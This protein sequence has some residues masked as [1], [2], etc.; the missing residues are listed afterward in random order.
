MTIELRYFTGT[1]NS[2]KILNTIKYFFCEA[3]HSV[4]ISIIKPGE[5]IP[6]CDLIGFCFPVYAFG[7][8]RIA[9]SY[10]KLI[11]AFKYGQKTFVI[12]TA[13][14]LDESGFAVREC[15]NLLKRKNCDVIYSHVVQ[16]P[17]N[18]ITAMNPPNKEEALEIINNGI[19][20]IKLVAQDIMNGVIKHHTFNI[21]KRYGRFGLYKEYWLFKYLGIKNLW[22]LFSVYESCNGCQV[23][24][25]GCP[26]NSIE[27]IDKKPVWKPSCEQC[28]RCVNLCPNESIYQRYGGSTIGRNRYIEPDFKPLNYEKVLYLT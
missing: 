25:R 2:L 3:N 18:W 11:R 26:T 10:L 16:M 13:G 12:I 1:G 17:I 28:M 24:A 8:P 22:R 19:S 21:P 14:D 7:I 23:C 15:N 27:I 5:E 4:T 6:N 20:Q 9:K